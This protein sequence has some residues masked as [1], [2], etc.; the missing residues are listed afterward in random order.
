VPLHKSLHFDIYVCVVVRSVFT[1]D[2]FNEVL[3]T[4]NF[5]ADVRKLVKF[6]PLEIAVSADYK[7][8][9]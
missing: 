4:L 3:V 6:M 2:R 7:F 9:S 1:V 5:L 8:I